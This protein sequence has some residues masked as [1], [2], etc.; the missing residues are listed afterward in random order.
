ML[1]VRGKPV[2]VR[3]QTSERRPARH[4]IRFGVLSL[5]LSTRRTSDSEL[6]ACCIISTREASQDDIRS[7]TRVFGAHL[8]GRAY[9]LTLARL[10]V[11]VSLVLSL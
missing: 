8:Q 1:V 3:G 11:R 10:D 7:R 6:R 2:R 4:L 5:P 9:V